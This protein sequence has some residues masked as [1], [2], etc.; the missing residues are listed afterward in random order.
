MM[1]KENIE[2]KNNDTLDLSKMLQDVSLNTDDAEAETKKLLS[3]PRPRRERH[4]MTRQV[5]DISSLM[6]E[7]ASPMAASPLTL[8]PDTFFLAG[9]SPQG[10]RRLRVRQSSDLSAMFGQAPPLTSSESFDDKDAGTESLSVPVLVVK[11]R[12]I[13]GPIFGKSKS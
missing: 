12:N 3:T 11:G 7:P 4:R 5:S 9:R 2:N 8:T 10:R 13:K 6:S 1:S